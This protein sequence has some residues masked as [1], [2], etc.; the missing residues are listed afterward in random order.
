MPVLDLTEL[1]AAVAP[2]APLVGLDL[3]EKTIGV[4]V[5]DATRTVASPL[6]TI[7]KTKFTEDAQRLFALMESRG[8]GGIVIGLPVNMDGT[9]GVRC[10]SNRAFARNL[11][12]LRELPIAFWDERMSTMA[13]NRMLIEEMDVTRARRAEVVDKAAAAW[14]LQGALERLR[15]L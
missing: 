9:E 3:G 1:P 12:R 5:S 14:I 11:L 15:G 13:V 10:Q 8:A 2:Y 7:R 6:Q 4:A